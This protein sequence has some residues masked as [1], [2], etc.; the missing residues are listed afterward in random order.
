MMRVWTQKICP[1][2]IHLFG[3]S[4]ELSQQKLDCTENIIKFYTLVL[5]FAFHDDGGVIKDQKP[6]S[7]ITENR[8]II[9]FFL[10]WELL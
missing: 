2:H 8:T 5:D 1:E 4:Q 7:H 6:P 3:I 10:I 9:L